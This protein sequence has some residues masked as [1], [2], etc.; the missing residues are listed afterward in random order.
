MTLTLVTSNPVPTSGPIS[1]T[2][3][4]GDPV[5]DS[6]IHH[7]GSEISALKTSAGTLKLRAQ[8][9]FNNVNSALPDDIKGALPGV[10][11]VMIPEFPVGL[12]SDDSLTVGEWMEQRL[13]NWSAVAA[14][15]NKSVN[16]QNCLTVNR[17]GLMEAKNSVIEQLGDLFSTSLLQ[18]LNCSTPA[19][20]TVAPDSQCETWYSLAFD[21]LISNHT[22][23]FAEHLI[24]Q[25]DRIEVDIGNN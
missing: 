25:C 19:Q 21:Y 1:L 6:D 20:T 7:L 5:P 22:I 15:Y 16:L 12:S 24:Q 4:A 8:N 2:T 18:T 23:A 17:P 3:C 11:S 14:Y 9:L 10:T 13:A